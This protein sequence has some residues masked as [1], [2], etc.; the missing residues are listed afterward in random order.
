[1]ANTNAQF[2]SMIDVEAKTA[3]LSCIADRHS[4]T[5]EQAFEE[6]TDADAEHLLDYMGEPY[7]AA[8]SILMQRH[9]MAG[10]STP[11]ASRTAAWPS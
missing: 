9:G 2:L 4:I 6:V 11:S 5:Q 7:R 10:K 8:A 3:I 1:M